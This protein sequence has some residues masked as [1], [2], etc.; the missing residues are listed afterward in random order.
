MQQTALFLG[1]RAAAARLMA[2][3]TIL[4]GIVGLTG[5]ALHLQAL[6]SIVPGSVEM[7]A[8]TAVALILCGAAEL[9]LADRA[10]IRFTRLAQLL[11]ILSLTIGLA[12]L[13]EY[14]LGWQLGIDEWLFKD[15]AGV[16]NVFHGRMSPYSA[17][18]FIAI[19]IALTTKPYRSLNRLSQLAAIVVIA[20]GV[21]SLVGYLLNANELVTDHWLPPAAINSATCFVLLGFG[22]LIAPGNRRIEFE[23]RLEMLAA[24]EIKIL[25]GFVLALA[26]LLFGGSYT[27]RTSLQFAQAVEWVAH[28]QE[29]RATVADVYGALEGAELA[30][31]D[32]L[33]FA[34]QSRWEEYQR[35]RAVV[36]THVSTLAQLTSD[37]PA[38]QQN[39]SAL[40]SAVETR[41]ADMDQ[42]VTAFKSF[43][44]PAARAVT[45]SD[46]QQGNS[47]DIR[48]LAERMDGTE[49]RLLAERQIATDR[50]RHNT[51]LSL[52]FTL[53]VA[54]ALF[55]ALFRAIH[56][57]MIARREAEGALR[58]S[59]RYNRS[60]VESSPDCVAILTPDARLS[61]MTPNGL[62]MMDITDFTA[63]AD[64]DWL[65]SWQ[66]EVEPAARAAVAAAR[67]GAAGRFH[68]F[69]ETHA[70]V[71]KW[72][73]VII[74]PVQGA[75][76]QV[77]R[78]LTVARDITE[79][80]RAENRLLEANHF[81][82][83][84]IENLPVM[85]FVKD[86]RTLRFVRQNRASEKLLGISRDEMIGKCDRDFFSPEEADFIA[87]RDRETL[88]RGRL[89]DIPEETVHT[90]VLG[91]RT[92]HTMKLPILDES[93]TPQFL[94]GISVDITERKLAEQAIRELNAELLNKTV[95]L[96]ATNK[97][98]ESFSYSVSHDLRAPLRAIDGYAAMLEEDC[99]ESLDEKGRRY[100]SVVRDSSRRMGTLIDDLLAF[101]RLGRQ[102]VANREVNCDSLVREVI[103][104]TLGTAASPLIRVD[105]L[106]SARGDRALLRQVWVN[107][108]AN[109]IKYSSKTPH[110][111]I[112]VTGRRV[113]AETI[114][115]VEDNG[116]GFDMAY[117]EKLFG[118][119]QRLH[120]ADEFGGTGVGLAIVHRV[121]TRHGGRVWAE[122]KL[123]KGAVFSFALPYGE[124]NE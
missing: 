76:G 96:E 95:Q 22:S 60:I 27:Y 119:F 64:T 108:I 101:S 100:L 89:V 51:L 80:K 92:L 66:G 39:L 31:R 40:R 38:Q 35:L 73:D 18:A 116:V 46:Q 10:T 16:Y 121:V 1:K 45:R 102:P 106:P 15:V 63:V 81:L 124:G 88:A 30:L 36:F 44:L 41:M 104:E 79:V 78:L 56:R 8:N 19:G 72:W 34:D 52:F 90:R 120:R 49:A 83:S 11:A 118:V 115:S 74:M 82:D 111:V 98:L 59:D 33:I 68:G 54:S 112:Q 94:L 107:L 109:A 5:W 67:G 47:R 21:I 48:A 70:G 57:E 69:R 26:L 84:L 24:V 20:I 58:A 87:D 3:L 97:E 114:Y 62:R 55:F 6:T 23:Q 77:E 7:K 86:A 99:R 12:T 42:V 117:V 93:G 28:T 85:V 91:V 123:N 61:Y 110:P 43:G 13:A 29:V 37:N 14:V 122:G 25:A 17:A 9:I 103:A 105:S 71:A 4:F 65:E 50:V 113:G 75:D 32:Y 53:A 2:A